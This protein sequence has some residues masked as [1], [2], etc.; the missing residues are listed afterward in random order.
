MCTYSSNLEA[1]Q[2]LPVN[3]PMYLLALH[4]H[5]PRFTTP[6]YGGYR[7]Q[8]TKVRGDL[9]LNI[10]PL[11]LQLKLNYNIL[12]STLVFKHSQRTYFAWVGSAI[13]PLFQRFIQHFSSNNK[14]FGIFLKHFKNVF[15]IHNTK[16]L[17]L[18][19]LSKQ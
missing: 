1:V 9:T 5:G 3:A 14:F 16:K 12:L 18:Y 11:R 2:R 6:V 4:V 13:I 8:I 15:E 7:T 17:T 19:N 10:N